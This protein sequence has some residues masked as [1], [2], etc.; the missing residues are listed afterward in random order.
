MGP[1]PIRFPS[2]SSGLGFDHYKK[3]PQEIQKVSREDVQ[4]VAKQFFNLD[5]Y[6]LAIIRPPIEKK[7]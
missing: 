4:R 7:E 2:T 3:Y 1:R 5:A 6:T